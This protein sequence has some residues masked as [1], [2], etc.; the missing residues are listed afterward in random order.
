M[1]EILYEDRDII[2]CVKPSGLLS[3]GENGD[4]ICSILEAHLK[5]EG[6]MGKVYLVHRLDRATGGLMVFAKNSKSAAELS[7]QISGRS[8]K[9]EYLAAVHGCPSEKQGTFEDLLFKDSSKI[10]PLL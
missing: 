9:K 10:N 4:S 7:K 8:F 1:P 5:A 6:D 2:V 3:E